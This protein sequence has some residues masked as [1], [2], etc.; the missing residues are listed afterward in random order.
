MLNSPTGP[1]QISVSVRKTILHARLHAIYFWFLIAAIKCLELR[2]CK[3]F[4]FSLFYFLEKGG[5]I[6]ILNWIWVEF[7]PKKSFFKYSPFY[8]CL[9]RC[10]KVKNFGGA[11]GNGGHNLPNPGWNRVNW[12]AKY[13]GGQW[14]P[15]PPQFRH[16]CISDK[17][18]ITYWIF[19]SLSI[20][21]TDFVQDLSKL[22]ARFF[23]LLVVF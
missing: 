22:F 15:R 21:P 23:L 14:P 5:R 18:A 2:S 16:H 11:S 3:G 7:G 17:I 20:S 19:G 9:Q 4:G 12:S 1:N 8:N 13:W 10:R 6:W